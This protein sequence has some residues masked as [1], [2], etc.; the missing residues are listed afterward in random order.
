MAGDHDGNPVATVRRT[1]CT[2]RPR[3]ADGAGDVRVAHGIAVRDGQQCVPGGP[4]EC[5]T[6]RHDRHGELAAAACKI[7]LELLAQRVEV[8]VRLSHDG[9]TEPTMQRAGLSFDPSFIGELQEA[10]PGVDRPKHQISDRRRPG[11]DSNRFCLPGPA[12]RASGDS[13]K[14][15]TEAAVRFPRGFDDH[16]VE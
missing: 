7:F 8:A 2:H 11:D 10:H 1:H 6:A 12:R 16:L 4:F 13:R 5:G 9:A 3:I 14:G 15:I